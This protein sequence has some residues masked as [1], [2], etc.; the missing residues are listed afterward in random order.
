[1][2][3]RPTTKLAQRPIRRTLSAVEIPQNLFY[4]FGKILCVNAHADFKISDPRFQN[5]FVLSLS[6]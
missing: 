1:M 3:D 2:M 5:R 6:D 4:L